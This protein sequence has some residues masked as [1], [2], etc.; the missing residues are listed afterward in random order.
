MRK[1]ED[2][3]FAGQNPEDPDLVETLLLSYSSEDAPLVSEMA[4][5]LSSLLS[6]QLALQPAA[7]AIP[8]PSQP[9]CSAF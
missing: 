3:S 6:A 7:R 4:A 5:A 9:S 1:K 2:R 8:S